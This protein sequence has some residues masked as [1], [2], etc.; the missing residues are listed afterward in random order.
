MAAKRNANREQI[1]PH[2]LLRTPR[3]PLMSAAAGLRIDPA[4]ANR[5][6]SA[7]ATCCARATRCAPSPL[8]PHHQL[9]PHRPL[10]P[11]NRPHL[12]NRLL[13][14]PAPAPPP[15][16][17]PPPPAPPPAA[18]PAPPAGQ[19]PARP[20]QLAV[21]KETNGFFQPGLLLQVWFVLDHQ[22]APG[23]NYASRFRA[24]RAEL[25]VKGEIVPELSLTM[26]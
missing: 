9:R 26:S 16:A 2:A 7:R 18:E 21:G 11:R 13:P 8:R 19:E 12:R 20:P 10:R 1:G 6:R 5:T 22:Q 17:L 3:S 25:R 4:G 23:P 14:P 15:P 24:R